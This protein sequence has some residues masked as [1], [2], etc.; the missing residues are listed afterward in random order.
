MRPGLRRAGLAGLAALMLAGASGAAGTAAPTP[1]RAPTAREAAEWR[2]LVA[3]A[4]AAR[5]A[6]D[7]KRVETLTR[8]RAAIE[9]RT[10]GPE[11]AVTAAS[12]SW[13]AQALSRRG[14]DAEAEPFYRK[15][16]EAS[17]KALGERD[18]Q[19]LL[20]VSNLAAVLERQGRFDAAEPLR[21]S[22]LSSTQAVFGARS[23]EAAAASV[24]LGDVLRA[25]LKPAQAEPLYRAAVDIDGR[26]FGDKDPRLAQD[27]GALAAAL[28]DLGRHVEAEPLHRRALALRRA[29]FG[30]RDAATAQAYARVAANLDAQGRHAEAEP[31]YRMALAT[32]R[33]VRGP[34]H[35]ATASD[36]ADLGANLAAQGR[37]GEAEPLLRKALNL[38]RR[39]LGESR[40]D[41]GLS[42]AALAQT[43]AA[44]GQP[45][46]AEK[47]HRRAL[48]IV[49]A[50][51]GER[52]P[53]AA[54]AYAGLGAAL[55]AQ[56]RHDAASPFL[57]KALQLRRAV[58]GESH[59]ATAKAYDALAENQHRL[60]ANGR[61]EVF[62]S[63]A[64]AIVRA[65]RSADLRAAGSDPDA[66]IRR[67]RA[68]SSPGPGVAEGPIF[69]R[70]L[71]VAWLAGKERPDELMRLRDAAF[72]AA[73]DLDVSPAAR[74]LAQT[75]ARAALGPG[76]TDARV[77]QDL[78]HQARQLEGQLVEALP[79]NDPAKAAR[80]GG[81][82]DAV[83]RELAS[84]DA[85]LAR[86]NPRYAE[87]V[88]P[89]ALT[90]AEAQ[91]RLRP[92]EG[93]LL[94]VPTGADVHVFAVSRDQAAWNR[95]A[96]GSAGLERRLRALRCQ[97]DDES[98]GRTAPDGRLPAFDVQMA[99]AVYRDVLAPVEGALD[100]VDRLYVTASGAFGALPLG[101]LPVKLPPT[102]RYGAAL[103]AVGWLSDRYALTTLPA[104]ASLRV[105]PPPRRPTGPRT[106]F[107]G[108]GDPVLDGPRPAERRLAEPGALAA[109]FAPLPGTADELRAMARTLGA[110]AASLRLGPRATESAIKSAT[111]LAHADVIAFATHGL[112]SRQVKGVDEPGLVLTPPARATAGDD[113]V[114]TASEAAALNLSANWV[115]LSA[116]NTAGADGRPGSDSLS[117]LARA[118]LYAGARALLVSHW[119]V[120]DDAT[121]A[122]TVQTLAIQRANPRL[123]KAQALQRA[124]RVV[125]T[126]KLPNGKP[127]PGWRAEW[128]HPAYWAP[129]V[130]IAAGD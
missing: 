89:R 79:Q 9:E 52:H 58:L 62:A 119:R 71:S 121:A 120:F 106:A 59:P 123:T 113:G 88:V 92:G 57:D 86:G 32:D 42:Y 47:L 72:T 12:W 98:C 87:A 129:F 102:D 122:L 11:A 19:T 124:M 7:W 68:D 54:D 44:R 24:A 20:A 45:R 31:L 39:A 1:T 33:D 116:C 97:L 36:T 16:L 107:V 73:Q 115:I 14:R 64:M 83:G 60:A 15:A 130:L 55:T 93:L 51:R 110:P 17:R 125:R 3:G 10:Y 23:A 99:H 6:G 103:G 21:R 94:I 128:S 111:E 46:E 28:D 126:G 101:L 61:A 117:G 30:E 69:R 76:A 70:Y 105:G 84:L 91:K 118:F 75:A 96:G 77:R 43:L 35:P 109:A 81:A 65:R 108:F 104:V 53:A 112:L 38:R 22:L 26:L 2:S 5:A 63:Q 50:A 127:L 90:I 82:L 34:T 25:A 114:L 100:G 74:A 29:A 4:E 49:L 48:A 18:P 85:R 37:H 95:I 8:R 27:L 66:A 13:I 80:I 41:T 56:G 40:L 67:A 78:A